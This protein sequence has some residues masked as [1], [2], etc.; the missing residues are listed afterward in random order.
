MF[1]N[2]L[3]SLPSHHT[4]TQRKQGFLG[5]IVFPGNRRTR[6]E[7]KVRTLVP[8]TKPS[9]LSSTATGV[10]TK[11]AFENKITGERRSRELV[12]RN[13]RTTVP[14]AYHD[15]YENAEGKIST[16]P[17]RFEGFSRTRSEPFERKPV[18]SGPRASSR[19]GRR[20]GVH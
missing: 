19:G 6:H 9:P 15:V 10:F 17:S 4:V 13:H 5:T 18:Q 12:R 7:N 3:F 8:G 14:F 11:C 16:F 20:S 2:K 1:T